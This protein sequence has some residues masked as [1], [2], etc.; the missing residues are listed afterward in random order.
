[1]SDV[2]FGRNNVI[3]YR[4]ITDK[5][6]RVRKKGDIVDV[7]G[8]IFIELCFEQIFR[9]SG[10]SNYALGVNPQY[11]SNESFS[12]FFIVDVDAIPKETDKFSIR[13]SLIYEL[14]NTRKYHDSIEKKKYA[15]VEPMELD[16][17]FDGLLKRMNSTTKMLDTLLKT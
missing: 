2:F 4:I 11:F 3:P 9:G 17:I 7:S 6:S 13:N 15:N 8:C 16:E 14:Q 1:M 10:N 5:A 12:D